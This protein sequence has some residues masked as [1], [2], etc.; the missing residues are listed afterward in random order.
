MALQ[1]TSLRSAS[2]STKASEIASETGAK[3][4][5]PLNVSGAFH[6]PLMQSAAE[7]LLETLKA[8]EI[9]N[10]TI[11]VVANYTASFETTAAEVR[12]RPFMKALTRR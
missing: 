4:V 11:P 12:D 9:N 10:L 3:R 8:S 1:S 2:Q 5:V 6:S 7:S